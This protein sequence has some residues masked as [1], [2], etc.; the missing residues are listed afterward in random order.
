MHSP[1]IYLNVDPKAKF[2]LLAVSYDV[3]REPIHVE[4]S[5]DRA[6]KRRYTEFI[7]LHPRRAP[8][9]IHFRPHQVVANTQ[10]VVLVASSAAGMPLPQ[11]LVRVG[12][13]A[14]AAETGSGEYASW[15]APAN[16]VIGV[17]ARDGAEWT[18]HYD[19][20]LSQVHIDAVVS[21]VRAQFGRSIQP[22]V[23]TA[24]G[25]PLPSMEPPQPRGKRKTRSESAVPPP[26]AVL[27]VDGMQSGK[28]TPQL[29]RPVVEQ[30]AGRLSQV[31]GLV[32]A[33]RSVDVIVP[34]ETD[35]EVIRVTPETFAQEAPKI[36]WL[37]ANRELRH[38]LDARQLGTRIAGHL[39]ASGT[40]TKMALPTLVSP[41]VT[42]SVVNLQ[43]GGGQAA[44]SAVIRQV[45]FGQVVRER[46]LRRPGPKVSSLAVDPIEVSQR[47][48]GMT[49]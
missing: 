4:T 12:D 26:D 8:N 36:E 18:L 24:T 1:T 7:K 22:Q 47:Y 11:M 49:F 10:A 29:A 39:R 37:L 13:G 19:N 43:K 9:I 15:R 3:N 16:V 27:V 23:G 30:L 5:W 44:D 38:P 48:D 42:G 20:D 6:L 41:A 35:L 32:P 21:Q 17:F 28:L 40:P 46:M 45:V 34:S 31:R 14:R 25:T 33:V 2:D